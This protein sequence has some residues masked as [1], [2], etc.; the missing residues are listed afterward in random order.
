MIKQYEIVRTDLGAGNARLNAVI[1]WDNGDKQTLPASNSAAGAAYEVFEKL[2]WRCPTG[3]MDHAWVHTQ[4][5]GK[6]VG[7][8]YADEAV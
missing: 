6:R 8:R 4:M 5:A 7:A 3:L 2:R 1:T